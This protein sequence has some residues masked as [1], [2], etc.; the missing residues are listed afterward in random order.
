MARRLYKQRKA[1][2]LKE[3][4]AELV[5]ACGG[6]TEAAELSRVSKSQIA[7]YTDESGDNEIVHM[8]I[9]VV[10]VLE[11]ASG[12]SIVTRYLASLSGCTLIDLDPAPLTKPYPV[13][14]SEIGRDEGKMFAEAAGALAD[15][16]LDAGEA[17]EIRRRALELSKALAALIAHIDAGKT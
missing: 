6:Q 16:R 10:A 9:D 2:S 8:P 17:G 1:G 5:L 7:R 12:D 13:L 4:V 11:R 3:A 14:L 15:G